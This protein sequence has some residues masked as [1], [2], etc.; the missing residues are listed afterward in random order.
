MPGNGAAFADNRDLTVK[1][2]AVTW[3]GMS[4]TPIVVDVF[5]HQI[6]WA[7]K[8]DP[9][10]A[11]TMR[12]I[13]DHEMKTYMKLRSWHEFVVD[14]HSG[15]GGASKTAAGLVRRIT[16][17]SGYSSKISIVKLNEYGR[18]AGELNLTNGWPAR[19]E[20]EELDGSG[21]EASTV[22]VSFEYDKHSFGTVGHNLRGA[23]DDVSDAIAT[24]RALRSFFG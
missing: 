20:S 12:F 3:P 6:K 9:S 1:C 15:N 13:E 19:V 23:I 2:Q 5:G 11:I 7:G 17:F 18:V 14:S 8:R 4:V 10:E 24:A 22:N 21:S 16:N